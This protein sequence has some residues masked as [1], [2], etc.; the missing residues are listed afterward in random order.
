[1]FGQND[2]RIIEIR[3]LKNYYSDIQKKIRNVQKVN[4]FPALNKNK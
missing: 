4:F 3:Q 2:H 1:M